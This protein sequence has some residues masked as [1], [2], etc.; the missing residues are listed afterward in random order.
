M[1][2]QV[3]FFVASALLLPIISF[4]QGDRISGRVV[5]KVTQEPIQYAS[6]GLKE[7]QAGVL[8]NEYGFFQ[9]AMLEKNTKDSLIVM[10]LGYKRTAIAVKRGDKNLEEIIIE[11]PK[12]EYL[13]SGVKVEAS[14]IKPMVWV[15]APTRPATA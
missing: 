3:L 2:K 13:L 11:V 6:I 10:A 12:R 4:A 5:D 15:P 1:F 14:K 7:E 8:T 9:I